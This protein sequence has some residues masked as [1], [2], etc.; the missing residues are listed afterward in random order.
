MQ[1]IFEV[2]N[3]INKRYRTRK[4]D[5]ITPIYNLIDLPLML[6]EGHYSQQTSFDTLTCAQNA[7]ST[8]D[9]IDTTNMY[10]TCGS[11]FLHNIN[12][13]TTHENYYKLLENMRRGVVYTINHEVIPRAC[14]ICDWLLSSSRDDFYIT[15]RQNCQ[16]DHG[17]RGSQKTYF[18]AY[19]IC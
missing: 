1:P 17:L 12:W 13:I 10:T 2:G 9:S 4:M 7:I 8:N 14:K 16:S 11:S 6:S 18:K 3:L 15:L 5:R 19:I